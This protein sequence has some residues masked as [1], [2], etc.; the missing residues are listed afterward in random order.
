M[1]PRMS[2][3]S[4]VALH[5]SRHLLASAMTPTGECDDGPISPG[6]ECGDNQGSEVASAVT[7]PGPESGHNLARG[8]G[9]VGSR[10]IRNKNKQ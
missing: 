5:R 1:S 9:K 2:P 8:L 4:P 3:H 6:G 10:G 7:E